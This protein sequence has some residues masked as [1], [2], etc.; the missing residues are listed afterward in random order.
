AFFN[1]L[2]YED[3]SLG[4]SLR[5]SKNFLLAYSLLKEKR[6][7]EA[8]TRTGANHRAAWAFT[9][10]GD[11]T[12]KLPKPAP[13]E[14]ALSHV[15]A[16]VSDN[17]IT[18]ALPEQS[19]SKVTT[20]KYQIEMLPNARLAGLLLKEKDDDG[21][22]LVPFVFAEVQLKAKAGCIPRLHSKTPS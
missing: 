14:H 10:W 17:T 18:I 11:P 16:E 13:P 2:A 19:H 6:L 20:T 21:Q 9:L 22:P 8:A 15:R 5:Q 12:L 3:Q 1:A 4:C 7:G